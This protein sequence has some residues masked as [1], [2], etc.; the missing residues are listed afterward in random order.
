MGWHPPVTWDPGSQRPLLLFT[1]DDIIPRPNLV[2]EHTTWHRKYPANNFAILGNVVW[3]PE[4]HP[5]P[6][7]E[8]LGLGGALFGYGLLSPGRRWVFDISI[9]ATSASKGSS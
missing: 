1:D 7:M 9:P 4:L 6:F 3:S 2:A 8:W 5:T